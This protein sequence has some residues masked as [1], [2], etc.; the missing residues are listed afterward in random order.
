MNPLTRTS[1]IYCG[2][3][4]ELDDDQRREMRPVLRKIEDYE[5]GFNLI[6][7]PT[8]DKA[9]HSASALVAEMLRL[10]RDE[11][12]ELLRSPHPIPLGRAAKE[13]EATVVAE[14]LGAAGLG[15]LVIGDGELA[16]NSPPKRLRGIEFVGG[17][18]LPLLFNP[19]DGSPPPSAVELIVTG[20]IVR[21]EV[22][23]SEKRV[24]GG[25]N[26]VL[27]SA[28]IGTDERVLDV[29]VEGDP[30]GF[31]IRENG[32]DFSCL[33]SSKKMLASENLPLLT[34]KLRLEFPSAAFV[35]SYGKMRRHL[36]HAWPVDETAS[37]KGFERK[38]FGG[39]ARLRTVATDNEA[40]FTRFSRLQISL[41]KR[42][43]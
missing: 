18:I 43:D 27:D 41:F 30:S 38:S 15:I 21:R 20:T 14:K 35:D 40:Q 29:Y 1:C 12:L 16:F 23:S 26:R 2:I 42:D 39:Y 7:V 8:E 9:D 36:G 3:D 28:E 6:F 25:D 13:N 34:E 11:T 33:G 19:A 24:R 22:S 17:A 37:S 32:F 5:P 10:D 31:R 4:L